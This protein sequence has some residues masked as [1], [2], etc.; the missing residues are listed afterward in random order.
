MNQPDFE[1][2]RDNMILNQ[3]RSWGVLDE[4]ILS[5]LNQYPRDHFVELPYKGIAYADTM[6]PL[7]DTQW[8]LPP[9]LEARLL[10]ALN[11]GRND[12][13]LLVGTG[14]GYLTALLAA[15]SAFVTSVDTDPNLV[16]LARAR[17]QQENINNVRV[18]VGDATCGWANHAPYDAILVAG[19]VASLSL[20]LLEQLSLN[21]TLVGV[22][23]VGVPLACVKIIKRTDGVSRQEL[24]ETGIPYFDSA[25][26]K[27]KFDF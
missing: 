17:L 24:F 15:C 8:M 22:E 4:R 27:P 11:P 2:A 13:V 23:G 21:G 18:E 7:N 26:P 20:T 16:E 10:Q 5:L 12:H 6:L 9:K 1:L 14:S 25:A 19:A 3:V